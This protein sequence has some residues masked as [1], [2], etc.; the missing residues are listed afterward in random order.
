[1]P[2]TSENAAEFGRK[3]G[4]KTGVKK[5]F[6]WLKENRPEKFQE[7]LQEKKRAREVQA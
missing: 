3:G 5:G 1:M 6:A 2:F 7:I 4:K